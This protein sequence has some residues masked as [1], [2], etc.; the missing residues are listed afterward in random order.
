MLNERI[1]EIEPRITCKS[2]SFMNEINSRSHWHLIDVVNR[3]TLP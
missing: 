2:S 3:N 1:E